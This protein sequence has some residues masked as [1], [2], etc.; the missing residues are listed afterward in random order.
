MKQLSDFTTIIDLL[1]TFDTEA[2]C[3]QYMAEK[4]WNG[5]PVCPHCWN[6]E[7]IYIFSNGTHYKCAAC[8]K[9]FT[10]RIGTI[11]EDSKIPLTKWFAAMYLFATRSKPVSSLQLS[12]D[13]KVTQKSAWFMLHRLRYGTSHPEYKKPLENT[14]EADETYIGGK[15]KNRR[16]KQKPADG[17]GGYTGRG[18]KDKAPVLGV[19]ERGG[20][21]RPYHVENAKK[22]TIQPLLIQSVKPGTALYTDEWYG[23][24]GLDRLYAHATIKH[25]LKQYVDGD[26]HTNTIEGFWSVLKR[27]IYGTY[28]FTS[29]KHLQ[30]Y[31]EEFA[32][33][34]NHRKLKAS[35]RFDLLIEQSN[36]GN[37]RYK[38]LVSK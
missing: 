13:I 38:S 1:T 6:D 24:N 17:L 37:I 19:V 21:V 7:K 3:S 29:R 9:K 34:Y 27:G 4:R 18:G 31:L 8:L 10:V 35:E 20:E 22:E 33:R 12:R 36:I 30:A 16:W 11:F 2:K 5:K 23:Y 32:Y 28:H 25:Q 14:V 15:E 26:I